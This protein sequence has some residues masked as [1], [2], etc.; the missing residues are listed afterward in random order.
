MILS[1]VSPQI[2]LVFINSVYLGASKQ[3]LYEFE[4]KFIHVTKMLK[5]I[6]RN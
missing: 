6:K 4:N 3:C 5:M 1:A 2:N